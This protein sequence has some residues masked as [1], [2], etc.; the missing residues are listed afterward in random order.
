MIPL[1]KRIANFGA[2]FSNCC[3]FRFCFFNVPEKSLQAGWIKIGEAHRNNRSQGRHVSGQVAKA[4]IMYFLSTAFAKAELV[5]LHGKRYV[6][7][8]V[9]AEKFSQLI[10]FVRMVLQTITK[11]G[12]SF[13]QF[14]P[15]LSFL[16]PL[17][18]FFHVGHTPNLYNI[19]GVKATKSVWRLDEPSIFLPKIE[20][21]GTLKFLDRITHSF[22]KSAE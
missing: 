17:R 21:G 13:F 4:V 8:G 19:L 22:R 7:M 6:R 20:T 2:E 12:Q 14:D 16:V 10:P 9:L 5:R 11:R 18:F 15:T 3:Q 1:I